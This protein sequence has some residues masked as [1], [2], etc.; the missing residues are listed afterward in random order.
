M[1]R[2]WSRHQ[3]L[4]SVSRRPHCRNYPAPSSP[5]SG[6][7][8]SHIISILL[9]G[10]S[11]VVPAH[12][13]IYVTQKLCSPSAHR[14]FLSRCLAINS[15][16]VLFHPRY[17]FFSPWLHPPLLS[18]NSACLTHSCMLHSKDAPTPQPTQLA[19]VLPLR[20]QTCI[21]HAPKPTPSPTATWSKKTRRRN[22]HN[23]SR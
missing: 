13:L 18:Q 16:P 3:S 1:F 8:Y 15:Y 12:R 7:H 20:G 5:H 21:S 10:F 4:L 17:M 2:I 14:P 19:L 6:K 9:V 23:L 11:K 22:L